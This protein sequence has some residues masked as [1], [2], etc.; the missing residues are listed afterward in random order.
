M[1]IEFYRHNINNQDI[2]NITKALRA[3][4]LS[5]GKK[6]DD[7]EKKF[8]RYLGC[9][10]AVGVTCCTGAMHLALQAFGVG[11]GDEVITTPLTFVATSNAIIHAGARPV[12]VDVEPETGNIDANL[13]EGAIT[14]RTKAILPVHLY[15]QMVD[16]KKIKKIADKYKLKIIEDAAHCIEGNRDGVRPAQLGDAACFS[17]YATKNITCGEGGAIALNDENIA[18][19]L[20]KMR[21]QGLERSAYE[22]YDRKFSS[23]DM[24]VDGWK[25]NM[26]NLQASLLIGQLKRIE[27]LWQR[28]EEICQKYERAFKNVSG[29]DFPKTLPK[30]KNARW[31]FTIWVEPQKR[32]EIQEKLRKR[33]IPVTVQWPPIH[34][35]TFYRK[36]YGYKPGDFP[37]AEAIGEKTITLPLYPKL[38]NQEVDFIIKNVR[39]SLKT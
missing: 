38:K 20:K 23:P 24:T 32:A 30:V 14:K 35:L 27:K 1:K 2:K 15:G 5:T 34:L 21:L 3:T 4:F 9:R 28:R 11:A 22:R 33:G 39:A 25:Y 26:N 37:R 16:M 6:V 19:I 17:F 18:K 31:V 36:K 29:I 10:C 7:F 12:F 8:A 13:I